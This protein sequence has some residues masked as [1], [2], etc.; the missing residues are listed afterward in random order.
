MERMR[1]RLIETCPKPIFRHNILVTAQRFPIQGFNAK[2]KRMQRIV[3]A[4]FV[5]ATIFALG[6]CGSSSTSPSA[7][8]VI[9]SSPPASSQPVVEGERSPFAEM[10][11]GV[12]LAPEGKE[13]TPAGTTL[14]FTKDGKFIVSLPFEKKAQVMQGRYKVVGDKLTTTLKMQDGKDQTQTDTIREITDTKMVW[15]NT[16]EKREVTFT[17]KK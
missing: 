2:E 1:G 11:V 6:G 4:L 3:L 8:V 7:P 12:W 14:E 17:R 16:E 5:C 9:P 10:I 13:D 15:F